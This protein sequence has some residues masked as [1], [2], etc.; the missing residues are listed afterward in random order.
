MRY[1]SSSS[2]KR[3]RMAIN[4]SGESFLAQMTDQPWEVGPCSVRL[5]TLAGISVGR[6]SIVEPTTLP[7]W[8]ERFRQEISKFIENNP[9]SSVRDLLKMFEGS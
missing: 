2:G 6:T 5:R 7:L 8:T 3:L 4:S 1:K 9:G